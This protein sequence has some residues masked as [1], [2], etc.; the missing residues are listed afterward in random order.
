MAGDLRQKNHIFGGALEAHLS[1]HHKRSILGGARD[2]GNSQRN[3]QI[4]KVP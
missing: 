3:A 2:C 4:G 1:V